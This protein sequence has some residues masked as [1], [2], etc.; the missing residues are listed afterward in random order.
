M[1]WAFPLFG[2]P[3][4]LIGLVMLA[5]PLWTHRSAR[6]T[7]YAV[8]N[9]RAIVIRGGRTTS[10]RSYLPDRLRELHRRERNDGTGDVLFATRFW[11]DSEGDRRTEESG[12]LRIDNPKEVEARLR[13]LA[14]SVA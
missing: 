5:T 14:E 6:R 10:I 11:T 9:R 4:V 12:F 1:R 3:F 13:H 7:V 2:V 8:T